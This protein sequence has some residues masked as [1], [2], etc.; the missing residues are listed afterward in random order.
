[1]YMQEGNR[2]LIFQ[3]FAGDGIDAPCSLS[4]AQLTLK[5]DIW[6]LNSGI[7]LCSSW[8]FKIIPSLR[9]SKIIKMGTKSCI[10]LFK[11]SDSLT[12]TF[13]FSSKTSLR[14]K[15]FLHCPIPILPMFFSKFQFDWYHI[16]FRLYFALIPINTFWLLNSFHSFINLFLIF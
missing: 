14:M 15:L 8:L 6:S 4:I 9:I 11:T 12:G 7:W 3:N 13:L 5:M 1:M 10:H 2:F 16:H